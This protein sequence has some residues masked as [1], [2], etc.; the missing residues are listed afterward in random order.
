MYL[1]RYLFALVLY[2]LS[3]ALL[4]R[5][6]ALF[7]A[8][9]D[10]AHAAVQGILATIYVLMSLNLVVFRPQAR[11]A[12]ESWTHRTIRWVLYLTLY[13]GLVMMPALLMLRAGSDL[14]RL[15]LAAPVL[16]FLGMLHSPKQK[17]VPEPDDGRFEDGPRRWMTY[18]SVYV[19]A[20]YAGAMLI[21]RLAPQP[22]VRMGL[23]LLFLAK[24]VMGLWMLHRLTVARP[25]VRFASLTG[26]Q[27]WKRCLV[28]TGL[29]LC[30]VF[31]LPRILLALT[32]G[33]MPLDLLGIIALLASAAYGPTL[34]A[35]PWPPREP[36]P[37]RET[38]EERL[39]R[40]MREL[41]PPLHPDR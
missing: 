18:A 37:L 7:G 5:W 23:V 16:L 14:F 29:Y 8:R 3:Y 22:N 9:P 17:D 35:I 34:A 25:N 15:T 40:R 21:T 19:I 11:F 1:K 6:Q 28:H 30:L 36:R 32:G 38:E 10:E 20:T 31:V 12:F 13:L 33:A 2:Y 27:R 24:S 26:G 41:L 4:V 39:R